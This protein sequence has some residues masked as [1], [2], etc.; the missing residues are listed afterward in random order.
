MI[1]KYEYLWEKPFRYALA[2]VGEGY[3]IVRTERQ[4]LVLIEDDELQAEIVRR[5]IAAGAPIL[6]K[7]PGE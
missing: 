5:M 2:P 7:E 1:E 3:V 4:S 6:G